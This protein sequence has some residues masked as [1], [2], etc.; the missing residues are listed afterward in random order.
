MGE[1][2]GEELLKLIKVYNLNACIILIVKI[3]R[4]DF[5]VSK[6]YIRKILC[7]SGE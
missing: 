1:V 3:A 5:N 6:F 7:V 2:E 4:P